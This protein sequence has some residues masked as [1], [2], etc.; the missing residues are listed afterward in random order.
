MVTNPIQAGNRGTPGKKS[1]FNVDIGEKVEDVLTGNIVPFSL[2]CSLQKNTIARK[3]N[4]K[5]R[6]VEKE[7]RTK[8]YKFVNSKMMGAMA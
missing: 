5:K 6:A 2:R 7:V 1:T 3:I 4:G 8:M